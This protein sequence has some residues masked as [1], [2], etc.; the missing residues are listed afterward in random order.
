VVPAI[1]LSSLPGVNVIFGAINA[2]RGVHVARKNARERRELIAAIRLAK[3]ERNTADAMWQ[4]ET[5]WGD[6]DRRLEAVGK[7][8]SCLA[9]WLIQDSRNR[10]TAAS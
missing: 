10:L 6:E 2:G 7:E 4:L 5:A 9:D 3:E 1:V 8:L